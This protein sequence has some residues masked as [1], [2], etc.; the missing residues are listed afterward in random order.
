M[1]HYYPA[2]SLH[3][4]IAAL[5]NYRIKKGALGAFLSSDR[6]DCVVPVASGILRW[7]SVFPAH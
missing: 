1:D 2:A 3:C 6:D 5:P 4:R 7:K